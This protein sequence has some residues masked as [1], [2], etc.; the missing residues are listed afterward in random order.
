MQ[1]IGESDW[2]YCCRFIAPPSSWRTSAWSC[3]AKG[4]TRWRRWRSTAAGGARPEHAP[5]PPFRRR[6]RAASG[7]Q[8]GERDLHLGARLRPLAGRAAGRAAPRLPAAVQ[9]HPQDGLQFRLGLGPDAGHRRHLEADPA[10]GL[11]GRAHPRA[12][13]A[14][15]CRRCRRRAAG[16]SRGARRRQRRAAGRAGAHRAAAA[17]PADPAPRPS[18]ARGRGRPGHAGPRP[19]RP[20]R[21]APSRR[22]LGAPLVAPRLR[23]PAVVRPPGDA[24]GAG[25]PDP[26]G[27][28]AAH[29]LPE[30][31]ARHPPRRGGCRVHAGRQRA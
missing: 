10:R 15:A 21:H 27:A 26:R 17:A 2:R 7:R 24:A 19:G 28:P 18:G 29:R 12:P 5:A 23:G 22:P 6:G 14:R 1:W 4:S 8:R 20:R 31:H 13:H 11:V 16:R 25:R 9:L 30:R 3:T